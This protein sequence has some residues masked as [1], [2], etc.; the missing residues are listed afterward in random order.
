[1]RLGLF[2]PF[3]VSS[4]LFLQRILGLKGGVT[5]CWGVGFIV[6]FYIDHIQATVFGCL[7]GMLAAQQSA[8]MDKRLWAVTVFAAFQV[9]SYLITIVVGVFI[10]PDFCRWLSIFG[11]NSE[12]SQMLLTVGVFYLTREGVITIGWR[13]L[14]ESTNTQPADIDFL[15][16]APPYS[17]QFKLQDDAQT[18]A[19]A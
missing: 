18:V 19:R 15:K 4:Q 10:L 6:L 5:V 2:V 9:C 14:M 8:S 17:L 3:I 13:R 16:S 1:V 12:I 11:I 7:S